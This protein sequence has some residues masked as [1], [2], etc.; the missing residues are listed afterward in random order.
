MAPKT[1]PRTRADGLDGLRGIAALAVLAFHVWL[2]ARLVPSAAMSGLADHAWSAG[3]LGLVLFFALSGFL[4][5]GRWVRAGMR[6]EDAPRIR[7]YLVRRA[8]RVLP[9]YYLALAGSLALLWGAAG[10]P[11]VRM[12]PA[13]SLPLFAV[14]GQNFTSDSVM[15]LDPPT[16]TLAIEVAFYL[17]LPLA[18]ALALRAGSDRRRQLA[19]PLGIIGAGLAWNAGIYLAGLPISFGKVLPA[20]FPYFG[21]G[22][23]AA[24]LA[25]GT[26]PG[27]RAG[28]VLGALGVLAVLADT[29]IHWGP[30]GSPI[31]LLA[32][33]TVRDLPAALGFAAIV[34]AAAWRPGAILTSR[35]LM[36][37]G[38]V[39]Y[40]VYLW[41]VPLLLGIRA[42]GL[43]P[44]QPLAA[45]PVVALATLVV[46]TF[47]WLALER[48]AI[49]WARAKTSGPSPPG[50]RV[51]L[52]V[53]SPPWEGARSFRELSA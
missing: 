1:S 25:E 12:P 38:R 33:E 53:D 28:A 42:L 44:L 4:L 16:W 40:G 30:I 24:T 49:A 15:T 23:L 8:A 37:L 22:M 19:V 3:H 18:G 21:A 34:V 13:T 36:A 6:G 14:F 9:A 27:R 26:A 5:Y 35:P 51:G 31:L 45:L 50:R 52:G 2:Y 32:S 17:A 46:A 10:T 7:P 47:S 11:G 20:A 39:S 48:P 29:A 43:L 41:N